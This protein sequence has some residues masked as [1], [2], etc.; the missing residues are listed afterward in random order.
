[1][2]DRTQ[3]TGEAQSEE[4]VYLPVEKLLF[5]LRMLYRQYG[6]QPYRMSKFEKCTKINKDNDTKKS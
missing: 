6:Y 2:T 1:M 5:R 4:K 3:Y